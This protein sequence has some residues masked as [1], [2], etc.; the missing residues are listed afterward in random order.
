LCF[1]S[2]DYVGPSNTDIDA[3]IKLC[4]MPNATTASDQQ[5]YSDLYQKKFL[6]MLFE[7]II[8]FVCIPCACLIG[9][10][11]NIKIIQTIKQNE[12]KELK[13]DMYKYIQLHLLPHLCILS[14][15]QLH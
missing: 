14:H 12:T 15:Q 5:T 8:P 2:N 3:Q 11:L 1:D 9:L 6:I 4:L 13:E 7:D 10:L